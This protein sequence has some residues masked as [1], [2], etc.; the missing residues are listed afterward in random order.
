MAVVPAVE[1]LGVV[2]EDEL[3]F[4]VGVEDTGVGTEAAEPVD[5]IPTINCNYNIRKKGKVHY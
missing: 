4:V 3:P 5:I 1:S 2:A